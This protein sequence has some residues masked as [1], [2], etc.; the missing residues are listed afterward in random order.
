MMSSLRCRVLLLLLVQCLSP[1]RAQVG[2]IVGFRL[3]RAPSGTFVTDLVNGAVFYLNNTTPSYTVVAVPDPSSAKSIKTVLYGWNSKSRYRTEKIAPYTLCG[4]KS[5]NVCK[6]LRAG[7]H[8]VTATPNGG[9]PLRITFTIVAGF[10]PPTLAPVP[11]PTPT[12]APMTVLV[13]PVQSPVAAI[14]SPTKAPTKADPFPT[15]PPVR[16]LTASPV[17]K[18]PLTPP[19]RLPT[20][21]P[22]FPAIR[23]NCGGPLYTDVA[24]NQWLAD[25]YFVNGTIGNTSSSKEIFNTI[26]D[27]L[28]R[29]FRTG[30]MQYAI[31]VPNGLYEVHLLMAETTYVGVLFALLCICGCTVSMCFCAL[32]SFML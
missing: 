3:V 25:A 6:N 28:Y 20:V 15:K 10:P 27:D 7:V 5:Y 30:A 19:V 24:R 31:P 29:T 9:A 8:T 32:Y 23:I 21:A 2:R 18:A 12:M 26:D 1:S 4:G 22:T 11:V 14:V 17:T 16:P 13:A